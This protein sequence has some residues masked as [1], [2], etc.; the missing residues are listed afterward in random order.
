MSHREEQ[1]VR[2]N[3]P[4]IFEAD[5]RSEF[6]D[7]DI[8]ENGKVNYRMPDTETYK[9][10]SKNIVGYVDE[11]TK[12]KFRKHINSIK[13]DE[14]GG[15]VYNADGTINYNNDQLIKLALYWHD[16]KV[17]F[18]AEHKAKEQFIDVAIAELG[19][20]QAEGRSE[21][22]ETEISGDP[23][24]SKKASHRAPCVIRDEVIA[25]N[26]IGEP[27]SPQPKA[28]NIIHI[29]DMR[30]L[31]ISVYDST[32]PEWQG[33]ITDIKSGKNKP[34]KFKKV[35]ALGLAAC[36]TA[37]ALFACAPQ[38]ATTGGDN[39]PNDTVAAA[40]ATDE[41][42]TY[43]N[44]NVVVT[45]ADAYKQLETV[46]DEQ[47]LS[48]CDITDSDGNTTIILNDRESMLED[49]DVS[50]DSDFGTMV[51]TDA[52]FNQS[53][54]VQL[55]QSRYAMALKT[56]ADRDSLA[57]YMW[58]SGYFEN[59]LGGYNNIYSQN[60]VLEYVRSLDQTKLNELQKTFIEC[61]LP[62]M[63]IVEDDYVSGNFVDNNY[64]NSDGVSATCET[65]EDGTRMLK[66]I[67]DFGSDVPVKT[68]WIKACSQAGIILPPAPGT[69]ATPPET[70]EQPPKIPK[71]KN[72]R[73]GINEDKDL[74]EGAKDTGGNHQTDDEEEDANQHKNDGDEKESDEPDQEENPVIEEDA[75]KDDEPDQ[76]EDSA[77]EEDINKGDPGES[78]TSSADSSAEQSTVA[79]ATTEVVQPTVAASAEVAQSVVTPV[80][81]AQNIEP[82]AEAAPVVETAAAELIVAHDE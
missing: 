54:E 34:G 7:Y 5:I 52:F 73:E 63:T 11:E 25:G 24:S 51:F 66:V 10:Y 39:D 78:D 21:P 59:N 26:A 74:N 76:E 36:L 68:F 55:A 44:T 6:G 38:T 4:D 81:S 53:A 1:L 56:H 20:V 42:A 13:S 77:A 8:D 28:N 48:N 18:F 49:D 23:I 69:P 9:E 37:G 22:I 29:G 35:V 43:I 30:G 15:G 3:K 47:R 12:D 70:P 82:V 32:K 67:F 71:E 64:F 57:D 2:Y 17:N 50:N 27:A 33:T 58:Q 60:D 19:R 45:D 62:N 31:D 72:E 75:N 61:V 65:W 40:K 16:T 46:D 14:A 41:Q 80:E 79:A